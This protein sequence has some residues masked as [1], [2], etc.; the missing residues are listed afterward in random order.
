MIGI[1]YHDHLGDHGA[2]TDPDALVRRDHGVL[3]DRN[4]VEVQI[5]ARAHGEL[6]TSP[7]V[8]LPQHQPALVPNVELAAW[9]NVGIEPHRDTRIGHPQIADASRRRG[10]PNNVAHTAQ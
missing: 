9:S 10:Q 3:M 5:G 6:A 4:V 8:N 2:G 7:N 1:A